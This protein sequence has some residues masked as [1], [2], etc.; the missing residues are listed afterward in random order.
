RLRDMLVADRQLVRVALWGVE[1]TKSVVPQKP[2]D[3]D[4]PAGR[5][6]EYLAVLE[7]T[8]AMGA[9]RAEGVQPEICALVWGSGWAGDTRHVNICWVEHEPEPQVS[10][11]DEYYRTPKPRQPVF[12][13]IEA[14]WYLWA[15]W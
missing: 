9:S 3:G 12:R 4:F 2:P 15:D 1:T 8:G 10:S 14:H 11:L 5:Y 13:K 7:E 6:Q